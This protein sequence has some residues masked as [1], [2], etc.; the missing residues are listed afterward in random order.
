MKG[1][2]LMLL[3]FVTIGLNAKQYI[4][5]NIE[6]M[7]GDTIRANVH[8]GFD[9]MLHRT[10]VRLGGIDTPETHTRNLLEKEVGKLVTLFLMKR[11]DSAKEI[12]LITNDKKESGKFG[13]PMGVLLLDG[14]DINSILVSMRCAKEY[15]GKKKEKWTDE[16][17]NYIKDLLKR[18]NKK[19]SK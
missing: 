6:Q 18:F 3:L 12:I 4:L 7:D 19:N 13:R 8:L 10:V 9:I 1:L 11:I 2:F 15:Y 14:V 5:T 16:E 17:L